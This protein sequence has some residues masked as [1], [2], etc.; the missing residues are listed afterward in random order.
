EPGGSSRKAMSPE[1][2]NPPSRRPGV[3]L[4][5]GLTGMPSEMRP[6]ARYLT[7]LG[8]AVETPLLPGHGGSQRELLRT[9]WREWLGGAR[10]AL[11]RLPV[12]HVLPW[13][14]NVSY[15]TERPPY[16]L[17]DQRLQRLIGRA[18]EAAERGESTQYGL[19][20]TYVGALRQ[21]SLMVREVRRKAKA[22]QCPALV[23]H[24]VEDTVT[25]A[26][27]A[28]EIHDLLGSR[29]KAIH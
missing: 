21:L 15:W 11:R 14:A 20:R 2:T 1:R 23:L 6:V 19:F 24:S 18:V 16:G 10:D 25:S 4:L 5:H 22:V 28:H 13:A 8:Y 3:L 29:E 26:R 7:S 9:T 12:S 27:N 17:R